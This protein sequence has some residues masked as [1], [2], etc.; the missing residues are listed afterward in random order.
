M[1]ALY[2]GYEAMLHFPLI[3]SERELTLMFAICAVA[4]P[5][6]LSVMLLHPTHPVEVFGNVSRSFGTVAIY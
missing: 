1:R 5:S 4:R 3:F 6:R 2:E